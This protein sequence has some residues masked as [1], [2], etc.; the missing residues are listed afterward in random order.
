MRTPPPNPTRK[1]SPSPSPS[2]RPGKNI[3]D[4]VDPDIEQRLEELEAE[5]EERAQLHELEQVRFLVITP[6]ANSHHG[7]N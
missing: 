1:P 2:P 4:Y 7:S 5:E 6:R 3:A